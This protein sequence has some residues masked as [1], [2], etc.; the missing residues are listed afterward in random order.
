LI[1]SN[2]CPSDAWLLIMDEGEEFFFRSGEFVEQRVLTSITS[3]SIIKVETSSFERI[4]SK[5]ACKK[6]NIL[7]FKQCIAG[8]VWC[9]RL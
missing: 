2:E 5:P 8:K 7:E 1:P 3:S 6:H 4:E 9:P